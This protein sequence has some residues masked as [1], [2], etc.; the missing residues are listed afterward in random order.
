MRRFWLLACCAAFLAASAVLSCAEEPQKVSV[1]QLK[2]DPAAYNHKLVEVE[3]FVSHGFEDFELF[4]PLCPPSAQDIWLEYG[5]TQK[6]DTIYCCGPTA[7]TSRPKELSVEGISIPLVDDEQ[8]KQFNRELQSVHSGNFGSIARATLIGRFFAGTKQ[9]FGKGP[10]FW[11]GFGHMGCCSLLAIQQVQ[12]VAPQ[13]RDDLDYGE[14]ADQPDMDKVGCGYQYMTPIW[15]WADEIKAQ[16]QAEQDP[17]ARAFDDP[18]SVAADFLVA[19]LKLDRAQPPH[20]TEKRKSQGRVVY[21]WN[22]PGKQHSYMVV[23]SKPFLLSFYAKNPKRVAWV[24]IAGYD[25]SCDEPNS[26]TRTR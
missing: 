6:S 26:V 19:A 22:P 20:L 2:A 14:S 8:F 16:Q 3:G 23:V 12:A 17:G 18:E 1:C 9:Q 13:D 21:Q 7:G 24:V 5:G 10:V 15:P 11:S 4:D 25:S